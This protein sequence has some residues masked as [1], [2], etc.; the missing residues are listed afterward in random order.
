MAIRLKVRIEITNP[1]NLEISGIIIEKHGGNKYRQTYF[2]W[3]G[4]MLN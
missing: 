2:K 4:H 3:Y 1:K